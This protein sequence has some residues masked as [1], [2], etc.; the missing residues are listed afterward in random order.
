MSARSISLVVTVIL[1]ACVAYLEF[2]RDQKPLAPAVAIVSNCGE[3]KPG[4][5][6]IG[7]YG[8]Q[9]DVPKNNFITHESWGDMPPGPH[10]YGLRP[11]NSTSQLDISW[12]SQTMKFGGVPEIPA[13]TSFGDVEKRRI[14]DNKGNVI[15]EDSWGYWESERWRR[16]HLLG[17][18]AASYGSRNKSE[19]ASYGSVHETDAALFD[20]IISSTCRLSAPN[21]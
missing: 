7:D 6:R 8:F 13:L 2:F 14:V 20:G 17:W 4:I 5:R 18:I 11:K 3:L 12:H 19:L 1:L 10:G 21:P 9:F 16:V 15:G